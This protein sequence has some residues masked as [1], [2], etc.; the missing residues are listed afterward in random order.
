MIQ[1]SHCWA[2]TL[3]KPE[4]KETRVPQ[5]SQ[6][7]KTHTSKKKTT[8]KKTHTSPVQKILKGCVLKDLHAKE[9]F[10]QI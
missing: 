1:Q 9:L 7:F 8:K 2:Y 3:K 6:L 10:L 4:W 5:C